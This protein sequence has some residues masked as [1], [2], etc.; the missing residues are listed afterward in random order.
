MNSLW[1]LTTKNLK[2]LIRA[3]G[4]ALIV[5]FA[6]L[7]IILLLGLSYN[8]AG[9][10]GLTLGLVSP[11]IS[12]DVAAFKQ[13][14][15]ADG[16]TVFPYEGDSAPCLEDIKS[17]V[18]HTCIL[19][20]ESLRVE[21]NQ[22]KEVTFY[23]DPSKINLVWMVQ[24]TVKEKFNLKSQELSQVL[25]QDIL[26]RLMSTKDALA[27]HL[28]TI[29]SLKEKV[30]SAVT[31]LGTAQEK[32]AG[33][34]LIPPNAAINVSST[35]LLANLT[36]S[37]D[38]ALDFIQDAKSAVGS[39][40]I[41]DEAKEDE[42][43]SL[44]N[45]AK[46]ELDAIKN[47]AAGNSTDTLTAVL[48]TLEKQVEDATMKLSAAGATRDEAK[49]SVGEVVSVL[50]GVVS[51]LD[52]LY[53]SLNE[54]YATLAG[55][56]VTEAE[57]ISAPIVTKIEP[58]A[59]ESTYLSYLFPALLVLIVMFS[60]LL[61]GTTLVLMEKHSPAFFRNFFLPINRATFIA[62]TYFTNMI[63]AFIEIVIVLG[64]ALFFLE[65][66]IPAIFPVALILLIA[67]SVFTLLGMGVGYLFVSEDT[68]TL[69]SVSLGSVLLFVSGV[70]LP[71]EGL[72][73]T[74]REIV[75]LNP[76]VIAEKMVREVFIFQVPFASIAGEFFTLVGYA[77]GL[78]GI[79]LLLDWLWHKHLIHRFW[80]QHH[81]KHRELAKKNKNVP[82]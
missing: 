57:T 14:L 70:I 55:Q 63:L 44:L 73:P 81:H 8:T 72:S 21:S 16:F 18:V 42:I 43:K 54:V 71:L 13:L 5:I 77:A 30:S 48:T 76:F 62:T 79:I 51:S 45:D 4:S 74:V 24:E 60:S 2:I 29:Q 33:M 26:S 66:A 67:A 36:G 61:L 64:I 35:V 49:N 78:F 25:T 58:V 59:Q 9:K 15:E 3:K 65:N 12:D 37:A 80:Q 47:L 32:L 53:A 22:Q 7:L 40:G 50:Q 56:K 41:E 27:Q 23:V 52:S 38:A 28:T 11:T 46:K 69:A 10:Y 20:P 1:L 19:V 34:D 39:A 6:P 82:P 17:G 75:A 31:S 68:G